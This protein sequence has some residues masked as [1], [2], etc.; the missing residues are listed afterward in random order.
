MIRYLSYVLAAC[1]II[2]DGLYLFYLN[3]GHHMLKYWSG[4]N[5][6]L[7]GLFMASWAVM[8]QA[9]G[10]RWAAVTI[11]VIGLFNVGVGLLFFL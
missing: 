6:I 8:M 10:D 11:L 7:L 3:S 5:S 4:T 1:V 9:K 2:S